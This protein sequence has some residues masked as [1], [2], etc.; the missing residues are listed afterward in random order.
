MAKCKAVTG[1]A[2]K[3]LKVGTFLRHSVV[4]EDRT[5]NHKLAGSTFIIHRIYC[6]ET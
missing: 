3:G 4:L 6:N 1:S 2:V 5:R